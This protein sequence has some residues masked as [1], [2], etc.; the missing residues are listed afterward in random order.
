[1]AAIRSLVRRADESGIPMLLIRMFLGVF[2][3]YSAVVKIGEPI[4][5]LKQIRLYGLLPEAPSYFLNGTA[6]LLPWLELTCGIAL[7]LGLWIRSASTTIGLMLLAFTPAIFLR[8][9]AIHNSEG[10]PFFEIEFDCGCGMGVEIIWIKLCKN[11]G[12]FLLVILAVLSRSRRFSLDVWLDRR[13]R[14][15]RCCRRCGALMKEELG[16]LCESCS[17]ASAGVAGAPDIAT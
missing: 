10:I 11:T 2:F 16:E 12:L 6:V 15:G 3:I 5:F 8:A 17:V 9:M 4:D 7:V 13:R 1:M 14:L